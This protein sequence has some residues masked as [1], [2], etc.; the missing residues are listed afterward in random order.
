MIK[1]NK[2]IIKNLKKKINKDISKISGNKLSIKKKKNNVYIINFDGDASASETKQ[3]SRII[4]ALVARFQA[5]DQVY[6][7]INSGGGYPHSYGLLAHEIKRLKNSGYYVTVLIDEIAASGGYMAA[8]VANKVVC[9]PWAIIGSIGVV[10]GCFNFKDTLDLINAKY[11][12]IT[13]GEH[14][15]TLSMFG[16]VGKKEIEKVSEDIKSVH[17]KFIE[18]VTDHRP[19]VKHS[20]FNGDVWYGCDAINRHLVD[21]VCISSEYIFRQL[22]SFNFYNVE[23]EKKKSMVFSLID[24]LGLKIKNSIFEASKQQVF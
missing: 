17:E 5:M 14:K 10:G 15:R 8:C 1:E 16:D 18:H 19:L 13:S 11:H 3:I 21:E 12:Q 7:K 6:I 9:S 22:D 23:I 2:I 24:H 4:D 20:A